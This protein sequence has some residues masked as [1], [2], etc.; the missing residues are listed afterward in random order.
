[1]ISFLCGH[2]LQVQSGVMAENEAR[3]SA[4]IRREGASRFDVVAAEATVIEVSCRGAGHT[5]MQRCVSSAVGDWRSRNGERRQEVT[6]RIAVGAAHAAFLSTWGCW[7]SA[8]QSGVQEAIRA[9]GQ[10]RPGAVAV[11]KLGRGMHSSTAELLSPSN[12]VTILL[13]VRKPCARYRGAFEKLT[14]GCIRCVFL[15][16]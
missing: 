16:S 12:L 3:D 9:G 10:S 11:A 5:N 2:A 1:M 7:L 13:F 14:I 8:S 15:H 4:R 6:D